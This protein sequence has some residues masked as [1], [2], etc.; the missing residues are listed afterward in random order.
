MSSR[1][2]LASVIAGLCMAS[3]A[4]A[5]VTISSA[6]TSN[7]SCVSGV[8]SPTAANAVLNVGDLTAMLAGGAVTVN[9]GTG[10]LAAQVEDIIVAST[11]NWASANALTLDAYRSVT[12]TVP[13]AVNGSAPVSLITNDGGSGG[14]LFFISGG[15]LSFL[16][17]ANGLTING[18]AYALV[19]DVATLARDI[20]GNP[21]GSYALAAAYNAAPDGT[22]RASP[23][24]THFKG[25]FNALGNSISNLSMSGDKP[26]LGLFAYVG[27]GGT[28]NS[29]E[30]LNAN[31]RSLFRKRNKQSET[32]TLVG[33]NYGAIFNSSASGNISGKVAPYVGPFFGGLVGY[34]KGTISFS[35]ASTSI[36]LTGRASSGP[37]SAG[38]LTGIT[39][40]TV[41]ESFA[42]GSVSLNEILESTLVGGLTGYNSG[43]L[44]NCYATGAVYS[45][46]EGQ[47]GGLV[48][49]AYASVEASY[50]TGNPSNFKGT[51]VG[52][53]VG[54]DGT[55]GGLSGNYWDTTTSGITNLSQGASN[56]ANDP[57]ITGETTAQLQAGLPSGFDPTI[58][59][60]SPSING[61][62][63][64]LI[65]N[66]PQ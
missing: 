50:S 33:I 24:A 54:W 44:R 27:P 47:V 43:V 64:Y 7:M 15:S 11:F 45:G 8:C 36:A 6:A 10:S 22:Y 42:T 38:A 12:V 60:E 56:I 46:N 4:S 9:T 23:I 48:G 65:N 30:L 14:N 25:L 19:D 28:V 40:G 61:G 55:G 5:A 18:V 57:G 34:N 39:E 37:I 17:T 53:F 3:P 13:V 52:G 16:G 66:P 29:V 62:L 51:N 59:A 58:W 2:A 63:P 21:G 49:N 26:E 35:E 1:T 20:K 32:G 31:V 41:A